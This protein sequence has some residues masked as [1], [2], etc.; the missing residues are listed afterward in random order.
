MTLRTVAVIPARYGSTRFPGKPLVRIA[1]HTALRVGGAVFP[2][3]ALRRFDWLYGH[4]VTA[5]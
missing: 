2:A 1:A 4:D 3:Q 5:F